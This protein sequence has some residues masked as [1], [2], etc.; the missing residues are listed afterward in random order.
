MSNTQNNLKVLINFL[1]LF[2]IDFPTTRQTV[3]FL[4]L[5]VFRKFNP[6]YSH[7]PFFKI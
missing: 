3:V 2:P 7:V 1:S 4:F 6:P 5:G